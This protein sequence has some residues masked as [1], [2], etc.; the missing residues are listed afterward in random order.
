MAREHGAICG[1]GHK[2]MVIE[3]PISLAVQLRCERCGQH[4]FEARKELREQEHL[5][6]HLRAVLPAEHFAAVDR[7]RAERDAIETR[8]RTGWLATLRRV[9]DAPRLA[10]LERREAALRGAEGEALARSPLPPLPEPDRSCACGGRHVAGAPV[11][12][13]VCRSSEVRD[14]PRVAVMRID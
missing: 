13:P 12:C 11:R 2:F 9:V 8:V 10:W 7:V 5:A 1:C 3:G 14:D 4:R 6:A